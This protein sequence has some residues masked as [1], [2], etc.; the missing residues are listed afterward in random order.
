MLDKE[1]FEYAVV[2]LVPRVEREE[3]INVGVVLFCKAQRFLRMQFQLDER[4]CACL[5]AGLDVQEATDYLNLFQQICTGQGD[6]HEIAS[7]PQADRFRWLTAR[8]SA[9]IQTSAVHPGLCVDAEA[10][11]EQLYLQLVAE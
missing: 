8:R 3:F 5:F 2:R 4:R 7:L 6:A 9:V 11:L 10:T 1:L